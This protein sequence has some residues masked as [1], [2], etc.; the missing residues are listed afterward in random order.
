[1][2]LFVIWLVLNV[3]YDIGPAMLYTILLDQW[4]VL[5]IKA[6]VIFFSYIY[7]DGIDGL[8]LLWTFSLFFVQ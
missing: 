7:F 6:L 4:D 1:M 5:T 3:G 2:Q 8:G